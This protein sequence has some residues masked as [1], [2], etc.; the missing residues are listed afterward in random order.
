MSPS[1]PPLV[2]CPAA[3]HLM[4]KRAEEKISV[5]YVASTLYFYEILST[6]GC[7]ALPVK[8]V[9][10]IPSVS[11]QG[12]V[13]CQEWSGAVRGCGGLTSSCHHGGGPSDLRL[14]GGHL[15]PEGHVWGQLPA[16]TSSRSVW[17]HLPAPSSPGLSQDQDLQ[18]SRSGGPGQQVCQTQRRREPVLH[19]AAGAD[20]RELHAE[21]HV[22][23]K[24]RSVHW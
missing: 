15:P 21:S 24:E 4:R 22:Q 9:W 11:V 19:H 17:L 1:P 2:S 20:Q 18:L 10:S 7:P 3:F 13:S 6:T 14:Q 12:S 5:G 8:S 23:R 16:T